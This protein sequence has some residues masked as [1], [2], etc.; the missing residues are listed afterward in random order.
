VQEEKLT[1]V[2]SLLVIQREGYLK[3]YKGLDILILSKFDNNR[4]DRKL[5]F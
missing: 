1:P 5:R 3:L 2:M 4:R